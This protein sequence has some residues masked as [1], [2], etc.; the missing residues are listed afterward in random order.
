M[1]RIVQLWRTSTVRLTALFIL[2][3]VLFSVLLLAFITYQSSI[4]LQR[5]QAEDIN[6]EVR[7]LQRLDQERG[8]RA[9][10]LAIDRL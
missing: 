7:E 5:Q 8:I 2:F 6:R 1:S 10:I 9:M 4:Q 3:F